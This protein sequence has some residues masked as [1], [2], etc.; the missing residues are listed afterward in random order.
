MLL[1]VEV[2]VVTNQQCLTSM[3]GVIEEIEEYGITANLADL[4]GE[5]A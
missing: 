2:P 5:V 4:G 1:E 3:S